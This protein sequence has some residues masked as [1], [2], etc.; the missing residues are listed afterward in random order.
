MR[1]PRWKIVL[2]SALFAIAFGRFLSDYA[3]VAFWPSGTV[4]EGNFRGIHIGDSRADLFGLTH[5]NESRMKLIG[6]GA[7]DGKACWVGFEDPDCGP[8]SLARE[9]YLVRAGWFEEHVTVFIPD[10]EVGSIE[11]RRQLIYLD[12]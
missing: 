5:D 1:F 9:Y 11:Y 12:P 6:Y 10:D 7:S 2:F 8:I 4:T 3:T